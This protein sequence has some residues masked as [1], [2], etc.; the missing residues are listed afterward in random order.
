MEAWVSLEPAFVSPRI[1]LMFSYVG[2]NFLRLNY[3]V[4]FEEFAIIC[5]MVTAVLSYISS[6]H[7]N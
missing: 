1:F 2:K 6:V 5:C 3:L 7:M 4:P